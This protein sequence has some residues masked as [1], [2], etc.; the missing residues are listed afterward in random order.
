MALRLSM[1]TGLVKPKRSIES[2][3]CRICFLECVRALRAA[4][5][6]A[7]RGSHST[8]IGAVP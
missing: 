6:R 3:I 7:A 5:V 8:C 2:A 4:G 1:S